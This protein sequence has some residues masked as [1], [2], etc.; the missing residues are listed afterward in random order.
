[1]IDNDDKNARPQAGIEDA[2]LVYEMVVEGGATRFFALLIF[3]KTFTPFL[4]SSVILEYVH[5][6]GDVRIL[7]YSS[8]LYHS[9]FYFA[10]GFCKIFQVFHQKFCAWC[11]VWNLAFDVQ[12]PCILLQPMIYYNIIGCLSLYLN[13]ILQIPEALDKL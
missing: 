11:L 2:Y 4:Y 7:S 1:M 13:S 9:F 12:K 3:G 5:L 8:V 6:R 10:R